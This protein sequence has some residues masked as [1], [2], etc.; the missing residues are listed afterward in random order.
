[1]V[2]VCPDLDV[3]L[4]YAEQKGHCLYLVTP[5]VAEKPDKIFEGW[6]DLLWDPIQLRA[7]ITDLP[8]Q[9]RAGK[10]Y[11]AYSYPFEINKL[12]IWEVVNPCDIFERFI[13][14][15]DKLFDEARSIKDRANHFK[16]VWVDKTETLYG[17][18]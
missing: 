16:R 6:E 11:P 2:A 8:S 5:E 12:E 14:K 18:Y 9:E 1:M 7:A 10:V 15:A 4:R 17:V 3:L 13:R